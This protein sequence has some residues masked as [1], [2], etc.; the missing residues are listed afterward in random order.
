MATSER[1]RHELYARLEEVLGAVYT[2]TLMAHLPPSGWGD[3]ATKH[4]LR[5]LRAEMEQLEQRLT[6]KLYRAMAA[7]TGALLLVLAGASF[8]PIG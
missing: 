1:A 2:D 8:A 6:S 5:E 3:V 4:D 7:Q